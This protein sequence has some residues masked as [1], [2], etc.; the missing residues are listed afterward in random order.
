MDQI[1]SAKPGLGLVRLEEIKASRA[2]TRNRCL[3]DAGRHFTCLKYLPSSVAIASGVA[4]ATQGPVGVSL[5]TELYRAPLR[6]EVA[7]QRVGW[8]WCYRAAI[9]PGNRT[10]LSSS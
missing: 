8:T 1:T 9:E 3:N 4:R 10:S 7:P 5:K 6:I 2:I